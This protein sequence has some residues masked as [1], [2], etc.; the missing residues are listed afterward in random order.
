MSKCRLSGKET[1]CVFDLGN[2]YMSD[3]TNLGEEARFGKG[4]LKMMLCEESGLLQLEEPIPLERMYGKYWYRSGTNDTMRKKLKDV[5]DTCLESIKTE[6]G[7]VFLDIACNDGTMFEYV[8]DHL[9]KVGIDPADETF[10]KEASTKADAVQRDFFSAKAYKKTPYADKKPKIITTIAMFY[11][12]DDPFPF[13]QDVKQI[14][15]DDGLWV[16]QLSYTPLMLNQ[17]AFDNIC[18]EHI[19]YYSLSSLK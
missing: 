8:P 14:L 3:F 16:M 11:D 12:L 7:D 4:S 9:I 2:L 15:D 1:T 5:A 19:C 18:H 6:P 13:A 10:T 17:L